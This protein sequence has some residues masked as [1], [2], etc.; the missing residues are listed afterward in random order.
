MSKKEEKQN[1]KDNYFKASLEELKKVTWL[2]RKEAISHT[3]VVIIICLVI[4]LFL[5]SIDFGLTKLLE[6][7]IK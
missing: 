3:I 4:G 6:I 7:L 2:S 1:K 5:G